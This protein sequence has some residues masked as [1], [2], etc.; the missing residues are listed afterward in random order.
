M[1][2]VFWRCVCSRWLEKNSKFCYHLYC[3]TWGNSYTFYHYLG[4]LSWIFC[5]IVVVVFPFFVL[6]DSFSSS[7][8]LLPLMLSLWILLL[9][10]YHQSC[11]DYPQTIIWCCYCH[12]W[13]VVSC[14]QPSNYAYD[15]YQINHCM[16]G[17][18]KCM[19][20]HYTVWIFTW[21]VN[22]SL[23]LGLVV[24]SVSTSNLFLL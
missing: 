17:N 13:L 3:Q 9:H 15:I 21:P 24:S 7:L 11:W 2:A 5:L 10:H 1:F 14:G 22:Y 4:Y 23:L 12:Y 16:V 19:Y 18:H 8:S 6:F 20:E